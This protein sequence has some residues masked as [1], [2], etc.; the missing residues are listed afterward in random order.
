MRGMIDG[1]ESPHPLGPTLPA[2]FQDDDF[3][4]RFTAAFDDALAPVFATLDNVDSYVDPKVAP[5]DFVEWLS[6]WVGLALDATWPAD[7]RRELVARAVELYQWRGTAR[8]LAAHVAVYTGSEPQVVDNGGVSWS[9]TPSSPM[10]GSGNP[11]FTVRV[12]MADSAGVDER[13]LRDLVDAAKPA[14]LVA[15]VEVARS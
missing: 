9:T 5:D 1:L 8:G 3:A 4:Q 7:R 11:S 10:P 13:R 14:H 6:G 15:D 2:V 12:E